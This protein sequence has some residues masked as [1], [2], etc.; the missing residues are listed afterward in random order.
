ML[1][2]TTGGRLWPPGLTTAIAAVLAAVTLALPMSHSPLALRAALLT[3]LV[4]VWA[5]ADRAG[6]PPGLVVSSIVVALVAALVAG[7]DTFAAIFL[8][9]LAAQ[10]AMAASLR[11]TLAV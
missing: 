10:V 3:A 1:G 2:M 7:R 5:L 11:A 9:L 4:G 8:V 6:T